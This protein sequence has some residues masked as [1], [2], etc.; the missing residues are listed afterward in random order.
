M[1]NYDLDYID[2]LRIHELRD[3]A[4]KLG[5]NSPTTMKKEELIAKIEAIIE[6]GMPEGRSSSKFIN[7]DNELDFF[8]LLTSENSTILNSLLLSN[9]VND[10]KK[11]PTEKEDKISNKNNSILVKK[12][13]KFEGEL[14]YTAFNAT[15]KLS[16]NHAQYNLDSSYVMFGY[17]DIH[18]E[19]YGILRQEG[20]V[21]SDNDAYMASSLVKQHSLKKGQFLKCNAKYI[22]AGRPRVVYE[23]EEIDGNSVKKGRFRRTFEELAYD[24]HGNEYYLD[25]F[26]ISLNQ[27]ERLYIGNMSLKEVVELGYDFVEE[28]DTK[29]KL[30]N[31]K[32]RPEDTYKSND[33]LQIIHVPFNKKP[34]E[35]VNAVELVVERVKR[36]YEYA[37]ENVIIIYNF[38]ELI[39][40]FNIACE[41]CVDFS[42][43]NTQAINKILNILYMSKNTL[44][45]GS[46]SVVCI[47]RNGIPKDMQTL[48][49]LELIPLF[50]KYYEKVD[51]KK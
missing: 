47:D 45:D 39:R 44:N 22:M 36:E 37:Q 43:I 33:K 3:F 12:T 8:R 6:S 18:P 51:K 29:V 20:Y 7:T 34:I 4:R 26:G 28:N 23:V 24:E 35:M 30:I 31:I 49:E 1:N 42:K 2:N 41:G 46:C 14:P 15:F 10:L 25:K 48:M 16:Q 40:G 9:D 5:V 13:N 11:L 21:P 19:G 32:A 50:N 27:G 38:A 17:V